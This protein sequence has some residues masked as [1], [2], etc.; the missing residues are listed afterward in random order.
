MDAIKAILNN[1]KVRKLAVEA[2][3]GIVIAVIGFIAEAPAEFYVSDG[4]MV[5]LLSIRRAARDF[6][7]DDPP[8]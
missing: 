7:S 8:K 4:M 1:R 6:Q 2:A 3:A 5:V